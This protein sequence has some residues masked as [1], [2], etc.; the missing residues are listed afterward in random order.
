MAA[1]QFNVC[2]TQTE[3]P[4]TQL[5]K[6]SATKKIAVTVANELPAMEKRLP[7]A[8]DGGVRLTVQIQ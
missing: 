1:L 2:F 6:K 8:R 4:Y 5:P 7:L 3:T